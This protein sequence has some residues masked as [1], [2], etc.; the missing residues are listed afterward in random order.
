VELCVDRNFL[1]WFVCCLFFGFYQFFV[2]CLVVV[3]ISGRLTAPTVCTGYTGVISAGGAMWVGGSRFAQE[4]AAEAHRIAGYKPNRGNASHLQSDQSIQNRVAE[5]LQE[6]EN[7]NRIRSF[8]A[9]C[10]QR[11]FVEASG[12]S[13]Q[14]CSDCYNIAIS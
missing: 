7:I 14:Y 12:L 8:Q 5:L 13:R 2:C 11:E 4:F 9:R 3:S 10:P 6:G 1:F